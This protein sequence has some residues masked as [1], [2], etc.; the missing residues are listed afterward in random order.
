MYC[1]P[2]ECDDLGPASIHVQLAS[3]NPWSIKVIAGFVSVS[4]RFAIREIVNRAGSCESRWLWIKKTHL[5]TQ[6]GLLTS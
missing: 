6:K 5:K 3:V 2:V 1:G 4:G